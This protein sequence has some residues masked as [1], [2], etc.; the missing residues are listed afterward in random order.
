[1]KRG[2]S[3]RLML[4]PRT[5]GAASV[6]ISASPALR[7]RARARGRS[8]PHGLG[9]VADSGDDVLVASTATEVAFDRVADLGV[10]RIRVARQQVDRG[11][12]HARRAEAALETVLLP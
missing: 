1:M 11:H 4:A 6:V 10:G 3:T 12:D 8:G 9:G 2:S 5:S 7:R